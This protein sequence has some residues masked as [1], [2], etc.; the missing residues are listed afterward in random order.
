MSR[1]V[2]ILYGTE[3][4]TAE[5]YAERTGE[6]LEELGYSTTVTDMED[7]DPEQISSVRTLLVITS[8]YGN[9]D[10]PANAEPL[11]DH[12]MADNAPR[13]SQLRFSICGLGDTTYPRF[14]QCG[15]DFDRRFADLGGSRLAKRQDCDV[16]IDPPWEE[17][18]EWVKA[19][20]ETL[21]WDA[22]AVESTDTPTEPP[23]E[24]SAAAVAAPTSSDTSTDPVTGA[25]QLHLRCGP[26]SN[27][28]APLGR[29]R[30][31]VDVAVAVNRSL[32]GTEATRDV[33]HIELAL[34]STGF[35]YLPGDSI[36]LFPPNDPA[37]VD[38]ILDA[39]GA[40]PSTPVEMKGGLL[41]L[42]DAMITRLD[43]HTA[44]A[45]LADVIRDAGGTAL[46]PDGS[47]DVHVIDAVAAAGVE[48]DG[49]T[50]FSCLRRQ[51][52]RLYSVAS[53]P[54]VHP[55]HVHLVA[56]VVR[57]E[58]YGRERG[59]V[60]TS[61]MADRMPEGSQV[62]AYLQPLETFRLVDD[63]VDI[64]M[65]GPGT[66][67]APFRAF[68]QERALRRATGRNWLFFGSRNRAT[69]YLYSDELESWRHRGLLTRLDLAFSRDGAE[70]VYVQHRMRAQAK[71]IW[72]WLSNDAVIYVCGDAA[73]M[74]PDV[75]REL[76]QIARSEGGMD[77]DEARSWI[78]ELAQSGRYMRDVY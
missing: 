25:T 78:R 47:A 62:R 51:A 12:V 28:A 61:W 29:R 65:I 5:G 77:K 19:G 72:N 44:E 30:N 27:P 56:S 50:L 64:V 14:A 69:D 9:G 59:G 54:S 13:L 32:T 2:T 66:G 48:I 70:K 11:F 17:W 8:T 68:L 26:P 15:K 10:P 20:L 73:A 52:P 18:V 33:R 67:I 34:G 57:Y 7:F 46:A 43:V 58:A 31:P 3:T 74:A 22:A 76:Q 45:R 75:H 55:E 37:L 49:P 53:S 16:D 1:A 24:T 21:S 39:A 60:A 23:Q 36:G 42:R 35:T 71:A 4:F 6:L 63:N 41:T 40:D 38:A